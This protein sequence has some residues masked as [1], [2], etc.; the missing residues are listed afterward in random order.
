MKD[1]SAV[2]ED[3]K[4]VFYAIMFNEFR[5]AAL[6]CGYALA[7]HGSMQH[8]ID[9]FAF[10][11]VEEPQSVDVLIQ[12]LSDCLG[13]T[14]W[15]DTHF[16]EPTIRPHGRIVYTLSIYSDWHLDL[17]VYPPMPISEQNPERSV[18]TEADSSTCD[19]K[20]KKP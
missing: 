4:P 16:K 14:I 18:A 11:W 17:S 7:L 9:L 19:D 6:D 2:F 10:P 8:D 12:K 20:T 3:G 13:K 1:R 5:K 15:K